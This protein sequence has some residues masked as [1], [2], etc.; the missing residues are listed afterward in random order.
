MRTPFTIVYSCDNNYAQHAGVSLLSL[1][2]NNKDITYLDIVIIGNSL[3]DDNKKRL[4]S[5]AG[6]YNRRLKHFELEEVIPPL[7]DTT[8]N[9]SAYGRIFIPDLLDCERILYIDSDTVVNGSLEF[10][11]TV[12]LAD[13]L[14]GG[15]LDTVIAFDRYSVGL[16]PDDFYVNAGVIL[17]NADLWK[18][19]GVAKKCF[20]FI[21]AHKGNPPFNDQGTINGVCRK[22]IKILPSQYNVMNT[23][24][25]YSAKE[26]RSFFK[27]DT[28]Y[29]DMDFK[30]AIT[31]PVIIHYTDGFYNRPWFSN[32]VHPKKE[33]YTLYLSFTPWSGSFFPYR[34]LT[35]NDKIQNVVYKYFPR[36]I[37]KLMIV[38]IGYKHSLRFKIKYLMFRQKNYDTK[39]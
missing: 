5:I 15:I 3:T 1:L 20:A 39:K 32:C 29:S 28:Y 12:D 21:K 33:F 16:A 10:L 23:M 18:K 27:L 31:N 30:E 2:E 37:Y 35:N 22:R 24:F 9:L 8:F 11:E 14:V 19:E 38:F 36:W 26:I 34:P 7:S 6:K 17:I 4:E 25:A 13:N